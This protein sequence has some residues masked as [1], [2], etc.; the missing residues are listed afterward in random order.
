M[1]PN[2]MSLYLQPQGIKSPTV[3][4][5]LWLPCKTP[6]ALCCLPH[7]DLT[8]TLGTWV[9]YPAVLVCDIITDCYCFWLTMDLDWIC[10]N[11]SRVKGIVPC[12]DSLLSLCAS[13]TCR[14]S[15]HVG[16]LSLSIPEA[17]VRRSKLSKGWLRKRLYCKTCLWHQISC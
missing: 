7:L 12:V 4:L 6:T 9:H 2:S 8:W 11:K 1:H 5:S 14:A 16:G 10:L 15:G 17:W 13:T 3:P